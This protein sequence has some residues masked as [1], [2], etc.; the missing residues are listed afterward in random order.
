MYHSEGHLL[1]L[2]LLGALYGLYG[3]HVLNLS[4]SAHFLHHIL[5]DLKGSSG[6][7][8]A[9]HGQLMVRKLNSR[10]ITGLQLL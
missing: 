5:W 7:Q 10:R 3:W 6:P 4:L 9:I 1:V 2:W 8:S